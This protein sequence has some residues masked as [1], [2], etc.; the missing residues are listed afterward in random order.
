M[1]SQIEYVSRGR[2]GADQLANGLEVVGVDGGKIP[3]LM[4]ALQRGADGFQWSGSAANEAGL[5]G[6][7]EIDQAVSVFE[8]GVLP[9]GRAIAQKGNGGTGAFGVVRSESKTVSLLLA[10][11]DPAVRQAVLDAH[12]AASAV[13]VG[14]M[15]RLTRS[16]TGKAGVTSVPVK[17][18]LAASISHYSSSAGDP[19]L[20]RHFEFSRRCLCE[21][22]TWRAVDGNTFFAARGPAEAA[23]QA[24]LARQLKMR[25]GL[26]VRM[27]QTGDFGH[28]VEIPALR[29]Q[30]E[31]LSQAGQDVERVLSEMSGAFGE[32]WAQKQ[33][34]WRNYRVNDVGALAEEIENGID[35]ALMTPDGHEAM[36]DIWERRAPGLQADLC[37][38][39][40]LANDPGQ[41]PVI[42]P[43]AE[44]IEAVKKAALA[45]AEQQ[46]SPFNGTN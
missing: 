1:R 29:K 38:V 32:S 36:R 26:D 34:A 16:R 33:D 44:R 20:H 46:D 43:S 22:G 7:V 23:A 15:E 13:F 11:P 18:L 40:V 8:K 28:V 14:E 19:T 41:A 39:K 25:L 10:H 30:A 6:K 17:G 4:E 9:D 3:G 37:Q 27:K 35:A 5:V 21:D 42:Q 45:W 12:E 2:L 31:K 24:E